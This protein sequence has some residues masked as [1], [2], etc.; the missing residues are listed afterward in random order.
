MLTEALFKI[1]KTW[2]QSKCPL[3]DEWIMKISHTHTHKEVFLSHEKLKYCHLDL[4]DIMLI[5]ITQG[6]TNIACSPLICKIK[7]N[8]KK[9]ENRL[10]ERKK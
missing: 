9:K 1:D 4:E 2:K 5:E 6:K 10:I 3:T 8:K 7:K